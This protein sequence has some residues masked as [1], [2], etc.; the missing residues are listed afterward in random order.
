MKKI[1]A[2]PQACPLR[3]ASYPLAGGHTSSPAKPVLRYAVNQS[4]H[5]VEL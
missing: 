5:T 1:H 4:I 2:H 3:V